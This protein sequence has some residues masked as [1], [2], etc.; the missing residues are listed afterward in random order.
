MNPRS[1]ELTAGSLT[2]RDPRVTWVPGGILLG[3][4]FLFIVFGSASEF[5]PYIGARALIFVG[6][7]ILWRAI[8]RKEQ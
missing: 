4:G 2:Q 3:M 6:V 1:R 8:S 5:F 7:Y